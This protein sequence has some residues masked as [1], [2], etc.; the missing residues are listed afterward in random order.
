MSTPAESL[1][2]AEAHRHNLPSCVVN[3][4]VYERGGQRREIGL[5]EISEVLAKDDD[6]FIWV[7]LYEPAEE[8]L[9]KL[10][11][12]FCLHDLAVEDARNA[13]QRPKIETYGNSLFI[14]V[15]TAQSID[16]HIRFGETHIF[17]GPRYLVTVR[18]GASASY[19]PARARYER[20]A[21]DLARG[22]GAALYTVLDLIVDNFEP[23]VQE[24][25]QDLNELEQDIFAEEFRSDT[26]K[27]LYDLKRELTRLRMAV[28]PLQDI[29]GQL[30][31]A[32]TN[33]ISEESQL[34]FRD[35]LDHAVRL[36]ETTDT[37][38]EMLTAAMSVN[39][40]LVT[41]HQ[42]EIVKRLAGWAALLAAPTLITSWYGMNFTH[43]P[44]L[45]GRYSYWILIGVVVVACL[46]LYALLRRAKWL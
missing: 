6:N 35:V 20:D 3:C 7:G 1:P 42:G 46:G 8:I 13:H 18:H 34:Y 5:D 9:D 41:I 28:S 44:E 24:F 29:L 25:S 32:R 27:H 36:N 19:A 15:H 40:S 10:Q 2:A 30:A 45:E 38:R 23:I 26:V 33:L 11:E 39:L 4:A 21:D 43:M 12:E 22:P 17:V 14:V 37:L 31:R 16:T